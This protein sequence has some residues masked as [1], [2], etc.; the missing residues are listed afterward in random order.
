MNA[1][2]TVAAVPNTNPSHVLPGDVVGAI[3]CRPKTRPP[4]YANVAPA[5]SESSTEKSASRPLCGSSRNRIRNA[6]P[7]AIQSA[8]ITV[9]L[10]AAVAAARAREC[11]EQ[12]RQH[13]GRQDPAQHP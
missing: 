1:T 8:P 5:H 2:K 10:T 9:A 7:P 4:K 11:L 12:K 3:L 13:E 6:S